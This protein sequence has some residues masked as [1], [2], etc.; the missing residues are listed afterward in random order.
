M[1]DYFE[2]DTQADLFDKRRLT[3]V[4][5][6]LASLP[7]LLGAC[8]LCGV[9]MGLMKLIQDDAAWAEA[10]SAMFLFGIFSYWLFQYQSKQLTRRSQDAEVYLY[11]QTWWH[12]LGKVIAIANGI[13]PFLGKP[14][15]F[16]VLCQLVYG[17]VLPSNSKDNIHGAARLPNPFAQKWHYATYI[18][19]LWA[20]Y[21][22]IFIN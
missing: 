5:Y 20:G 22:L 17:S 4:E 2:Y 18:V 15:L 19:A 21:L 14:L 13:L 11:A 6:V 12:D 8:V 10:G 16:V 1:T 9:N 7:A 3:R